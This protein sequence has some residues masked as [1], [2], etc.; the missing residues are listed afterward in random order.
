MTSHVAI[1][2]PFFHIAELL[3]PSYSPDLTMSAG[4]DYRYYYH[5][6]LFSPQFVD[7]Y[8]SSQYLFNTV[9]GAPSHQ[10][11]PGYNVSNLSLGI[12]TT[13][14]NQYVPTLKGVKLSVGI[15]KPF[16]HIAELLKPSAKLWHHNLSKCTTSPDAVH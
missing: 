2:K 9:T 13:R 11:Q 5:G 3:K 10:K 14:L 16:F 6:F 15:Y 12:K 1:I 4:I 8:T 7:Q